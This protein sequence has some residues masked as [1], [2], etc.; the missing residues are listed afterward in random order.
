MEPVN[1]FIWIVVI[2]VVIIIIQNQLLKKYGVVKN[3]R[4]CKR[5]N[6]M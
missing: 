2:I 6:K 3:G 4:I 1:L 5:D